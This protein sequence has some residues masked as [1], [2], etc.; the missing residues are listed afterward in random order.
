[1]LSLGFEVWE[2]LRLI[3]KGKVTTY[4]LLANFVGTKGV[5][6]V[7]SWVGK[8][9]NAPEVPCHRVVLSD[10]R[11]G[12]YSGKGGIRQKVVLLQSE[13]VKIKDGK[14]VNFQKHLFKFEFGGL[15]PKD[16]QLVLASA[17][18]RRRQLL[19][20]L[21]FE[22]RITSADV[23]EAMFSDLPVSKQV[24]KLALT[25]AQAVSKKLKQAS[26][27]IGADTLV[28]FRGQ[29]LG[30]PADI[31]KARKMLMSLS[32]QT[33]KVFSGLA[34]VYLNQLG[35][36]DYRTSVSQAEIKLKPLS[37]QT[38]DWYVIT[39]EPMDKAGAFA[40]QGLGSKLVENIKGDYFAVVGLSLRKLKEILDSKF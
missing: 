27:I 35:K 4:G 5:R 33:V 40:V 11:V 29:A 12:Q 15:V 1:M 37:R 25:K 26:I 10:G 20:M 32:G 24:E 19:K 8:N 23:D 6:A 39:G 7:A 36:I 18:P 13:G 31:E 14:I 16:Y 28:E 17:S 9:P 21:G 30:K 38:I 22:F 2:S 34:V 3:P